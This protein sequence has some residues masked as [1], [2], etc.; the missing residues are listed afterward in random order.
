ME[1]N[2]YEHVD[3]YLPRWVET[4]V[5]T[6]PETFCTAVRLSVHRSPRQTY[7]TTYTADPASF[8]VSDFRSG[9]IGYS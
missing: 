5:D 8:H 1:I 4:V 6:L 7:H 2:T 9:R 3:I